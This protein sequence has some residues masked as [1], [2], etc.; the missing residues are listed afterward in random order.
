MNMIM[1]QAQT[2][3]AASPGGNA[4]TA[5]AGKKAGNGFAGALVQALDGGNSGTNPSGTGAQLLTFNMAGILGQLTAQDDDSA[6]GQDLIAALAQLMDQLRAASKDDASADD[7]LNDPFAELLASLQAMLAQL[8]PAQLQAAPNGAAGGETAVQAAQGNASVTLAQLMPVVLQALQQ[9][10]QTPGKLQELAQPIADLAQKLQQAIAA[11]NGEAQAATAAAEGQVTSGGAAA[12][13]ADDALQ[14]SQ[15]ADPGT[16]AESRKTTNA[17]KSPFIII[18]QAAEAQADSASAQA[19][20]GAA[21]GDSQSASGQQLPFAWMPAGTTAQP[22]AQAGQPTLPAQV[23]VQQFTEQVGGYLVKHFE[24]SGGNGIATVKLSLHPE[25]L[26][27]VDVRIVMQDGQMTAQFVAHN[28]AA[29][30]AIENQMGSLRAALL[31]QGIQVDKLDVVQQS[32]QTGTASFL[33]HEQRQSDSEQ[34]GR[35]ASKQDRDGT[36]EEPLDFEAEMERTTALRDAG[37]GSSINV[38]A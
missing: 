11:A 26:G 27:Q 24:V 18:H 1:L 9:A 7:K 36:F 4:G 29:K 31:G 32:D 19:V 15:A 20:S 22:S 3:G 21:A 5:Q 33:G 8:N 6:S 30:E 38:T 16:A 12:A 37:Y 10:S 17:F 34:D 13:T 25:H 35:R 14:A 23:P 2:A 28:S